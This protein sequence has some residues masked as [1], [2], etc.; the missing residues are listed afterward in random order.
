MRFEWDEAKNLSNK[1]KHGIRF[2]E[3]AAV[4]QDPLHVSVQD[5]VEGGE[6]RWQTFGM[7]G[8]LLLV[9]VAHTSHEEGQAG[10]VI[11]IISARQATRQERR[12]YENKTC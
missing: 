6:E 4:F 1:R 12:L 10:V 3:A 7:V 8:T 11:R 5:R 9:M 2:E